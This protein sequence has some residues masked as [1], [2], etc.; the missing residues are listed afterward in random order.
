MREV[1]SKGKGQAPDIVTTSSA[2]G[3]RALWTLNGPELYVLQIPRG[4][5]DSVDCEHWP[6]DLHVALL[7][8]LVGSSSAST[9]RAALLSLTFPSP[10]RVVARL[11]P[12]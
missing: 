2:G 1:K 3:G 11:A 10:E 6:G 7:G 12:A 9:G 4:S 5:P 8:A